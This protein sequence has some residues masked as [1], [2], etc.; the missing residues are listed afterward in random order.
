M[1]KISLFVV[2]GLL[3]FCFFSCS[4]IQEDIEVYTGAEEQTPEILE[5]EKELVLLEAKNFLEPNSVSATETDAIIKKVDNLLG[6]VN[7]QTASQAKL[8]AFQGRLFLISNR[9]SNAKDYYKQSSSTYAGEVQNVILGNRLGLIE[10]L[11]SEKVATEQLPYLNLEMALN[12]YK[13]EDYLQ[14]I[15]K[16]DEAFLSLENFYREAYETLRNNA[17]RLKDISTEIPSKDEDILKQTQMTVVQMLTFTQNTTDLLFKY[18][19]SKKFTDSTLLAQILSSG[20][21]NPLNINT[22]IETKEITKEDILT[23]ILAARFLWNLYLEKNG[24]PGEVKYANQFIEMGFSPILDLP[25][26]SPDFDAVL[27]CI[28]N[29]IME[30]P[31]GEN[32][33]PDIPMEAVEFYKS[34]KKIK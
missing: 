29:E 24:I 7:L 20:L 9:T 5:V 17:W 30:L 23:R 18:T 21:L 14:A 8:L 3:L 19:A 26:D 34:L 4:T 10:N 32:F 11:S 13:N 31:D 16:F 28:E 22:S 15:A 6:N 2:F 27:G 12:A 1:K 25:L 33:Y